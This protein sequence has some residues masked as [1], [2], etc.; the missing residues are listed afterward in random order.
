MTRPCMGECQDAGGQGMWCSAS[1]V[2]YAAGGEVIPGLY[3]RL[4]AV[5]VGVV[6]E[7]S[8]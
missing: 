6:M 4:C 2:R 1:L 8:P 7:G 5:S 3:L